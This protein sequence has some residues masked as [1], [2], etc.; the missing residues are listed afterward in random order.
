MKK[1]GVKIVVFCLAC[2]FAFSLTACGGGKGGSDGTVWVSVLDKGFGSEW[3]R[4]VAA[5]Y[6]KDTGITVEVSADPDLANTVQTKMGTAAE[7]DDL[8]FATFTTQNMNKWTKNKWLASTDDVLADTTYGTSASS[9]AMDDM[10]L[11][12]GKA[13]DVTY[14][15]PYIY[16][17]WG[18][19]YNQELLDKIESN[20]A[21]T[22]G[23]FP[24]TVQGLIDLCAAIKSAELTNTRTGRTVSPFSCGLSVN[25]MD[26]LFFALWY[27][28]DP[29]GWRAFFDQNDASAFNE[30]TFDNEATKQAMEWVYKL[31]KPTPSTDNLVSTTQNHVEAQ[32]SFVNGDCVFTFCGTWF[33]TEMKKTLADTGMTSHRYTAYPTIAGG[34]KL[35][36]QPNLPGESFFIPSD[37]LNVEGAKDFLAYLMSEKGVAIASQT[38]SQPVCFTT[39]RETNFTAFGEDIRT[40]VTN[41]EKLYRF[42][43]ND[44][45]KTGACT[46]FQSQ[47]NPFVAISRIT[48]T[49]DTSAAIASRYVKSEARAIKDAWKT[50]TRVLDD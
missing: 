17:N 40:A 27:Q 39:D 37:A 24:A 3:V 8:Y 49:T 21:Y 7:K 35:Y 36:S 25:Y 42:S 22:K 26:N 12:L 2:A 50:F 45:F 34:D 18:M 4:A 5:E 19:I 10:L 31:M 46:L 16:S 23:Q 1:L 29:A 38:I 33:E 44:V 15:V 20:G 43:E 30:S 28:I 14:S 11:K 9:R 47:T 6:K 48:N 41:S 13:G 32:T